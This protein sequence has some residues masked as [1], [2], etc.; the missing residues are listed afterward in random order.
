MKRL[1][2]ATTSQGMP[3]ATK[4]VRGKEGVFPRAFRGSMALI[5]PTGFGLLASRTVRR[6]K[7]HKIGGPL[8]KH[9]VA[10]FKFCGILLW[11]P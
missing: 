10:C 5:V 8:T 11:Q 1:E 4:I 7:Y 3:G 9:L 6:A 2:H